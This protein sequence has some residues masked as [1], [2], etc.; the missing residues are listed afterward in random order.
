MKKLLVCVLILSLSL[1]VAS[2]FRENVYFDIGFGLGFTAGHEVKIMRRHR[3]FHKFEE[4]YFNGGTATEIGLRIG[5]AYDD[6]P[7]FYVIEF[8]HSMGNVA[9]A[10]TDIPFHYFKQRITE[11]TYT[12]SFVGPGIVCYMSP[13][14]QLGAS[15][16]FTFGSIEYTYFHN[17]EETIISD[18]INPSFAVSLTAAFDFELFGQKLQAGVGAFSADFNQQGHIK[19]TASFTGRFFIRY[20]FYNSDRIRRYYNRM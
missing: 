9:T 8:S 16:G 14:F 20:A 17:G 5:R 7:I 13:N 2:D 15:A 3:R 10:D 11:F 12:Q 19:H 6:I 4:N 1:L 18:R